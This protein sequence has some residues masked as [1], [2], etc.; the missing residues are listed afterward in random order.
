MHLNFYPNQR[1]LF[2]AKRMNSAPRSELS[3]RT[4]NL[5]DVRVYAHI[6]PKGSFP[7]LKLCFENIC[8]VHPE[9]HT[10]LDQG[11]VKNREAYSLK[12]PK[13]DWDKWDAKRSE[14]QKFYRE[15]T[16]DR[17]AFGS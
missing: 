17:K 10:I 4:I 3:G 8:L 15:N 12:Y 5:N 6:L 16:N 11:T 9:E 1:A 2:A 13:T 14:L 7:Y